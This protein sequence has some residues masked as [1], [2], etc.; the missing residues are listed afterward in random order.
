MCNVIVAG[1]SKR[2][3]QRRFLGN[4]KILNTPLLR[5]AY[6]PEAHMICQVVSKNRKLVWW[7]LSKRSVR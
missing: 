3:T 4:Y 6:L 7:K 5:D 2:A 1:M